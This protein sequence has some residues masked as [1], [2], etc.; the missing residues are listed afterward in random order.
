MFFDTAVVPIGTRISHALFGDLARLCRPGKPPKL[1]Q[2][3]ADIQ[4]ALAAHVPILGYIVLQDF[5]YG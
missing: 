1:P 2:F 5:L 4:F 3:D